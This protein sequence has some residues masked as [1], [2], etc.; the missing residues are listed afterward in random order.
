VL[1]AAICKQDIKDRVARRG[2]DPGGQ[3]GCYR[4]VVER[5]LSWLIR[6][7]RLEVRYERRADVHQAFL[8]LGCT[9]IYCNQ[10]LR[11]VRAQHLTTN[12]SK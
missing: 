7:R 8:E 12:A 3:L 10:V 1:R 2:V 5:A 4:R 6:Y 9:L 11:Q